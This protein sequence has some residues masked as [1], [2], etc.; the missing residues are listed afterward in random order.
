MASHPHFIVPVA[1]AAGGACGALARH[2]TGAAIMRL[3]SHLFDTHFPTGIFVI[4]ILGS[5]VMGLLVGGLSSR[6]GLGLVGRSAL[7][8]G[9]LGA[10][11]TFSTFSLDT[12][13]LWERGQPLHA[14][15][16]VLG[17]VALALAGLFV[18]MRLGEAISM[19]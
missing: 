4:N 19:G 2:Y 6:L 12:W 14:A 3:Q 10:F 1:V 8:V 11:T 18:G 17:S 5:I 7:H 15:A 9:F 16:Y 13:L